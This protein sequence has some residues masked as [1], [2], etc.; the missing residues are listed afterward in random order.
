MARTL[1]YS[2]DLVQ[3]QT[4]HYAMQSLLS[5]TLLVHLRCSHY[6]ESLLSL[7]LLLL[8]L[9]LLCVAIR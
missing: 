8:L 4:T 9:L 5:A 1:V 6:S 7:L 2:Y 3:Q